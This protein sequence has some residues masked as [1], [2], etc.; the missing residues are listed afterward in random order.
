MVVW[1]NGAGS[2]KA[3]VSAVNV[4]TAGTFTANFYEGTGAVA[5][6]TGAGASNVHYLHLWF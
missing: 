3:I 2:N 1:N 4:T 5:A 6:G